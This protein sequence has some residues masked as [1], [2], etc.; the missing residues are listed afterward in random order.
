MILSSSYSR[1]VD[2]EQCRYR[3]KLKFIDKIPEVKSDSADRGTA[4]HTVAENYVRGKGPAG[5]PHELSKF[6]DEF[7]VLRREFKDKKVSLEGEW[8]FDKDWM[9]CDYKTAWL[10]IKADAV[11]HTDRHHAVVID[12]KSGRK[13]G[14]EI[15]HGEQV[16]LYS[17]AVLIR[18]PDLKE[19]TAELW[20][21]DLDDITTRTMSR[22]EAMRYVQSFDTRIKRMLSAE[23]FPPNANI[24]TC[25]WCSYGPSKGGQCE[26]GVSPGQQVS[27]KSY[28]EKFG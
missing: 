23:T 6:E 5:I 21:V 11:M 2:F 22:L 4:I 19:V 1:L 17:I 20:Y 18:N 9:P 25:K 3:A 14:N 28:R 8:G 27:I 16:Q 7:K 15:K 12:Y 13:F 24:F 10:R 26:Y